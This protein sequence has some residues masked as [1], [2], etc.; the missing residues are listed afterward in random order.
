M[1]RQPL[2]WISYKIMTLCILEH[3]PIGINA[4][5]FEFLIHIT[6]NLCDL[7]RCPRTKFIAIP[8]SGGGNLSIDFTGRNLGLSVTDGRSGLEL[9]N[10]TTS[11][12]G[13]IG[14]TELSL[15]IQ[16]GGIFRHGVVL[17][18]DRKIS[19]SRQTLILQT[20]LGLEDGSK[21]P[22]NSGVGRSI[23]GSGSAGSGSGT[24]AAVYRED[25]VETGFLQISNLAL[26][27]SAGH[28]LLPV[29]INLS[30]LSRPGIIFGG[31]LF[32][33]SGILIEHIRHRGAS[34]RRAAGAPIRVRTTS[35]ILRDFL[36]GA[37]H[38]HSSFLKTPP[39]S[40]QGA[41][42]QF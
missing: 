7:L 39:G 12:G 27:G 41:L 42:W 23:R 17:L 2:L 25:R 35:N 14:G 34:K 38:M 18:S 6:V 30:L 22:G 21:D 13:D 20:H 5:L 1:R 32:D 31:V 15:A 11:S 24:L 3:I 19:L 33:H 16:L 4:H 40:F 36:S 29:T 10:P 26:V 9:G 37:R 28:T 8:L